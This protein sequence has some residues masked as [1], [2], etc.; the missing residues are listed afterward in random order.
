MQ[1]IVRDFPERRSPRLQPGAFLAPS[2]WRGYEPL[3]MD[4]FPWEVYQIPAMPSRFVA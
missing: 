2:R 3:L 4:R 1:E